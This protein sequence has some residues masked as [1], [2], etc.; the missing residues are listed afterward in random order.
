MA[1]RLILKRMACRLILQ[2]KQYGI[3]ENILRLINCFL[4]NREQI[5]VLNGQTSSW[6]NV[7]AGD[8]QGYILG[9]L[10]FLIYINDLSDDLSSNPKLFEDDTYLFSFVHDKSTS[11]KE[12]NNDLRKI[13][14]W[15][16]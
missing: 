9:P 4:K 1:C 3:S 2:L 6:T 12:L 5:I 11:A 14:N 13:S 10:F 16:Y 8:P 7:I 15:S